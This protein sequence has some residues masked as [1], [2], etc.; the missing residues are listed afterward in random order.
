MRYRSPGT[1]G[2]HGH[3]SSLCFPRPVARCGGL[4]PALPARR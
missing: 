4:L 3:S 1:G 2:T